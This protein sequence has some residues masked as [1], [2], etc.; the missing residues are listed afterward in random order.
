MVDGWWWLMMIDVGWWWL[1]MVDVPHLVPGKHICSWSESRASNRFQNQ[2][3]W[4]EGPTS[5]TQNMVS[6]QTMGWLKGKFT[7]NHGFSHDIWDFP[8]IFPLNQSI[9]GSIAAG[10]YF[11]MP[12]IGSNWVYLSGGFFW[13]WRPGLA[14]GAGVHTL[15]TILL[16]SLWS[17]LPAV[18]RIS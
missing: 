12:F 3:W 16:A 14:K 6:L 17:I 9:D 1:M 5:W 10:W 4:D 2:C 7:G 18:R 8:V 13:D 15:P 11:G